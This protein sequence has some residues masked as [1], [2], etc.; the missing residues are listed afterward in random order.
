MRVARLIA[1][2][3]DGVEGD[4]ALGQDGALDGE[5][6]SLGGE[7]PAGMPEVPALGAGGAQDCLGGGEADG[8]EPV[9]LADRGGLG[10]GLDLALGEHRPGGRLDPHAEG[11]EP[12][13]EGD[14][15]I[16]RHAEAAHAV[17]PGELGDD[18][19]GPGLAARV[20]RLGAGAP[21][22][23]GQH[24]VEGAGLLDPA[25]LE[26]ALDGEALL[27]D[28]ERDEGV[29]H[30]D[31]AEIKLVGARGGV[32]VKQGREEGL[33]HRNREVELGGGGD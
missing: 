25:E 20:A 16:V 3:D 19:G 26:R 28:P 2:G 4:A 15:K 30:S 1:A 13:E 6:Q 27:S 29:V 12:E 17:G 7:G 22:L 14:G 18:L 9:A 8:A 5:S 32:G 10:V 21:R 24:G 11:A 33:S 23:E 31:A